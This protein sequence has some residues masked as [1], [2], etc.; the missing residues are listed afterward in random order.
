MINNTQYLY[1]LLLIAIL[2]CLAASCEKDSSKADVPQIFFELVDIEY[3][4]VEAVPV[5][6]FVTNATYNNQTSQTITGHCPVDADVPFSSF[7]ILNA[8]LNIKN[9][10]LD[11]VEVPL[12]KI[13]DDGVSRG[14]SVQ[15]HSFAFDT[16]S[17]WIENISYSYT[18]EVPKYSV[19]KVD[20]NN[21]GWIVHAKFHCKVKVIGTG[22]IRELNGDWSGIQFTKQRVVVTDE[23]NNRTVITNG[24][25]IPY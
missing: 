5:E 10:N 22:E 1:R 25:S 12:P 4:L 13:D 20:I 19:Y 9:T 2:F 7:F 6:K 11:E 24:G 3:T 8:G 21:I 18:T 17:T 14:C 15:K 16:E 23:Q